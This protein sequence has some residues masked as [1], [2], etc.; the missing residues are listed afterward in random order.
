MLR[1][2]LMILMTASLSPAMTRTVVWPFFLVHAKYFP[3]L[4]LSEYG[5]DS[6]AEG[7]AVCV[8]ALSG[9]PVPSSSVT[10]SQNAK[11]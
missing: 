7:L 6:S 1:A 11:A 2:F 10:S 9:L 3:G 4:K 8:S 5:F